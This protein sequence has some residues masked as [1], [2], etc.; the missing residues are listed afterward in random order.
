MFQL[1]FYSYA[2]S[3]GIQHSEVTTVGAAPYAGGWGSITK[4]GQYSYTS[5]EGQPISLSYSADE[6]GFKPRG[7]HLPVAPIDPN[8]SSSS[9]GYSSS[10]NS[11][12][13]SSSSSY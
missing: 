1:Y 2:T 8:H 4:T 7:A 9:A 3:N 6:G 11:Y 10:S 12:G 13:G 5:P